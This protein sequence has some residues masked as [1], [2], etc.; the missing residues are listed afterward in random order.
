[1]TQSG[2]RRRQRRDFLRASTA[3]LGAAALPW[4]VPRRAAAAGGSGLLAGEGVVDI[5]PPLGIELAGFHRP[6]DTPRVVKGIRQPSTVRAIVLGLGDTRAAIVSM[7]MLAVSADFSARVQAAIERATGIPGANVR[8]MAT[9]THSMPTLRFLR[10]WGKISP[11]YM[12]KVEAD[13][14]QAVQMANDDLAPAELHL[15]KAR[16]EGGNYNRTRDTWKTEGE[17]DAASTDSDRWLDTMLHA[18]VF[19]RSG[20]KRD[21]LWYHFSAHPVCFTDEEAGPDWPGM[22]ATLTQ[23]SHK[24]APSFL[25]GNAG[26]VNPGIA[27]G[28]GIAKAEPTTAAIYKALTAAVESAQTVPVD[29]LRVMAGHVDLPYDM[30][31]LS[32]QLEQYRSDPAACTKGEW[33]DAKFSEDWFAA[34]QASDKSITSLR[35]PLSAMQLGPIGM[36]FHPSELYSYYGLAMKRASPFGETLEVGYTDDFVGY[37]PDPEAYVAGEYSALVVP[38]MVGVAP[39]MPETARILAKQGQ[40]LLVQLGGKA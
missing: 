22:V 19:R 32:N 18:L 29:Q 24:L 7:D 3:A 12:Q 25:Q 13:T 36:V 28:F 2:D 39:Y 37:L 14:L 27:K 11:E 23:E 6:P 38:K 30:A 9:H 1:M 34:A 33:V 26:D 4:W 17:F 35:T 15:G 8:I 10:Q 31:R 40:A 20:G 21:L 16:C 5:T